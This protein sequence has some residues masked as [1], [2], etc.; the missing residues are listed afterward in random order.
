[1]TRKRSLGQILSKM[2][3]VGVSSLVKT[4]Q[5]KVKKFLAEKA[6]DVTLSKTQ[7]WVQII[8]KITVL[9]KKRLSE[10]LRFK[11]LNILEMT[12]F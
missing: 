1:M 5:D 9:T 12:T 11:K 7:Q 10:G 6:S 2:I 4:D 8:R 3:L